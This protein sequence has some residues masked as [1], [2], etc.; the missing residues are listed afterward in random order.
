LAWQIGSEGSTMA[1]R[2]TAALFLGTLATASSLIPCTAWPDEGLVGAWKLTG[3]TL[4]VVGETADKEPFGPNPKGRLVMTPDGYWIVIITAANRQPARTAE[5]KV[6]LFDSVLAYSGKYTI[7][8]DKIT[9]QVDMSANEVFTGSNQT[10][11]RFF[12]IDGRQLIVRT[13]EINS[14]ALPGKKIVGT[15]IFEREH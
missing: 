5:E 15:N 9:I 1:N 4:R 8:G 7:E 3:W 2:T 12:K 13:P 6:A 11:T 10:Q 14:A